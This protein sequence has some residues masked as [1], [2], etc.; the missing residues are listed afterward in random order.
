VV[1]GR[2]RDRWPLVDDGGCLAA[3]AGGRPQPQLMDD[4]RP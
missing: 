4:R 2:A 3:A 1:A